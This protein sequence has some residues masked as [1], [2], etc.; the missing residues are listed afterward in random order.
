MQ[1]EW[2]N[3]TNRDFWQLWPRDAQAADNA[4]LEQESDWWRGVLEEQGGSSQLETLKWMSNICVSEKRS[5]LRFT[6]YFYD[7]PKM[8]AHG[9]AVVKL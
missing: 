8:V 6:K 5:W 1:N 2:E 4:I 3:M 9:S 7:E